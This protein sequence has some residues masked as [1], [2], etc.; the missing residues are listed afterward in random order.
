MWS[1]LLT[2]VLMCPW[3]SRKGHPSHWLCNQEA[4]NHPAG[5]PSKSLLV[6]LS[7]SKLPP[8]PHFPKYLGH[9]KQTNYTQVV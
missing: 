5:H 3:S 2:W 9:L 4:D 6:T 7:P 1:D 8:F